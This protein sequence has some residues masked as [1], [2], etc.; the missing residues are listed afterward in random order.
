MS[1]VYNRRVQRLRAGGSAILLGAAIALVAALFVGNR[2]ADGASPRGDGRYRPLLARGDGHLLYLMARSLVFDRNLHFDNDLR[3]FGDP[4]NQRRTAAGRKGIPHPIG[5]ALVWAPLLAGA[6]GVALAANRLGAAIEEHGYTL[7]HQRIVLASS[8]LFAAGAVLLGAAAARRAG[9]GRWAA[10]GAAA[11]V[12]L[13]TPLTFY[14]TLMP[15]YAHALDAFVAGAFLAVWMRGVGELSARRFA[16]LGLLLGAAGLVRPQELG[17]AVVVALELAVALRRAPARAAGLAVLFAAAALVAFAPQLLAWHEI[18]GSWLSLP[19]GPRYV[20][21]A[22]PMA[23]EVLLSTTH[24]W[25]AVT[26]LAALGVAGLVVLARRSL[27]AAGLLL[28]IAVQV[29][30]SSTIH[31]WW[32]GA[33]FGQR[34]LCGLTLPLVVGVA[35]LLA[36]PRVRVVA[37]ALA[38]ALVALNL[39]R[40]LDPAAGRAPPPT[41]VFEP[42][43]DELADG[44][45]RRQRAALDLARVTA[46]GLGEP[47]YRDGRWFRRAMRASIEVPI[48]M[49]DRLEVRL[50][51]AGNAT[52]RWN[53]DAVAAGSGSLVFEV[54]PRVGDNQL[55]IEGEEV[56]LERIEL[57]YA[58]VR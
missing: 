5:P 33:A 6:Q 22:H 29:Y 28:A 48:L 4:W 36:V 3:R 11:A 41:Y 40:V 20:R 42:G 2:P 26:P 50:E 45:Y 1:K 24:G 8:V 12:L 47:D 7:F 9:A 46:R 38:L 13:G 35:A 37:A 39:A 53:G 10:R 27:A 19:Q 51:L 21:L 57:A 56:E 34:R 32:G 17:L 31:D 30:L 49:P 55:A 14:A 52:V 58:S 18:Y 23:R 25:L 16:I 43:L 54:D 44:S 15:G